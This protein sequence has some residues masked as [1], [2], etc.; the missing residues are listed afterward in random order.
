MKILVTSHFLY[1]QKFPRSSLGQRIKIQTPSL[2]CMVNLMEAVNIH[3]GE[4][5]S[6][7]FIPQSS[8]VFNS[9]ISFEETS[10][11]YLGPLKTC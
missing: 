2:L 6:D 1:L 11:Y 9:F 10:F 4:P 5:N 7:N 8:N 3:L